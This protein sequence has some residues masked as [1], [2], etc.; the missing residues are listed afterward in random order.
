MSHSVHGADLNREGIS[1][2]QSQSRADL[3]YDRSGGWH[4]NSTRYTID[5]D[6][7]RVEVEII[8]SEGQVVSAKDIPIDLR[9][10]VDNRSM[11]FSVLDDIREGKSIGSILVDYIHGVRSERTDW[12]FRDKN[13]LDLEL[14]QLTFRCRSMA[15]F[16]I[17][18]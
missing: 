17:S 5:G 8:A 2:W 14:W 16:D 11:I 13:T 4:L 3:T 1:S 9:E 12:R 15:E 7:R 10:W 18:I 6:S